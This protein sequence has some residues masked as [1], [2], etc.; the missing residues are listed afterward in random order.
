MLNMKSS[1]YSC[2]LK[3]MTVSLLIGLALPAQPPGITPRQAVDA[4]LRN[5]PLVRV[6]QEQVNAAAA[7]IEL[8]RTA[9]LPRVEALAQVNRATRNNVF[10]LLLPQ[11]V[12]PSISGPVLGTNNFGTIW[13]SAVG[14]LVS[15]EPFDFG[16]RKANVAAALAVR[17]HSEATLRRSRFDVS[18][19]AADGFM[20]LVAAQE[21]VRAAQAALER[22]QVTSRT[23]QALVDA[24]LRPG[25]D[26]SRAQAEVA[27]ARTQLIRAEN[28]V[29]VSRASLAKFVGMEPSQVSVFAPRLLQMPPE[30]NPATQA[31]AANP[32][33]VEQRAAIEQSRAQLR[34]LERSWFPRVFLQGTAYARGSGA[35]TSGA[36]LGGLNGLA[37]DVQNYAGTRVEETE[38][39]VL[40]AL[41]VSRARRRCGPPASHP[42][43]CRGDDLRH[44]P[45]GHRSWGRGIAI[46]AA[47]QGCYQRP[48]GVDLRD[49]D[50]PA[51][52]LC[53]SPGQGIREFLLPQP[54]G[55]G[56]P[57]L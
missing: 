1:G 16:Y 49:A 12:V 52:D 13:G 19:A 39:I 48:S 44:G 45:D 35:E 2:A 32:V 47:R 5:Y 22:T 41:E 36:R 57:I 42:H 51:V 8:A 27:A 33:A 40:Y 50:D 43:D 56:E 53:D 14:T 7:G 15:W 30:V 10:G 25:A 21:T 17:E 28:A 20:T 34:V 3:A 23:T 29:E 6:S 54:D 18:V 37:P 9:Y 11:P 31:A 38:R 4:A 55:S 46:G 24:E 26:A